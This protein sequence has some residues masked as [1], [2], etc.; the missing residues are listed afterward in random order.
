MRRTAGLFTLVFCLASVAVASADNAQTGRPAPDFTAPLSTGG[1]FKLSSLRGKAVYLNYFANW[2]APCNQEAPDINALQKQYRN[3]KF[4][5]LGV[6]EQES[7]SRA[8]EFLHKYGSTYKAV[9][10]QDGSLLRPYG[11]IGLPV[12]VFIDRRGNIKLIRNGEMNKSE[13]EKA[14][15]SIL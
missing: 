15:R 7:A 3:R 13:I 5:V 1:N 10:D 6:D 9:L 14:I 11:A 2:C 8:N 12:H 4:V